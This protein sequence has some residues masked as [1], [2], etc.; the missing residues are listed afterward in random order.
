[1]KFS[2]KW[3]NDTINLKDITLQEVID[4]LTLAG[5][6]IDSIQNIKDTN[7]KIIDISITAN[8]Q[9]TSCIMGIAE[10]ISCIFN[11][12]QNN[13]SSY[14]NESKFTQNLCIDTIRKIK[15]TTSPRWIIHYLK[16]CEIKS[17]HIF[18]D[19]IQYIKI[20]WG[21]AIDIFDAEKVN[22]KAIEH[23]FS[24]LKNSTINSTS[25]NNQLKY[26]IATQDIIIYMK[27]DN[28]KHL[29]KIQADN[30]NTT[31]HVNQK[32][33]SE[34]HHNSIQAYNEALKLLN[35]YTKGIQGKTYRHLTT[36]YNENKIYLKKKKIYQT[37]GKT[38]N[39]FKNFLST[40]HILQILQQLYLRPTY[41]NITKEFIVHIPEYRSKDLL[42][43]IDII[44]EIGRIYGFNE[45]KSIK[46]NKIKQ[47]TIS[48]KTKNLKKAHK[49]LRD[50]GLSEVV[51]YSFNQQDT[52]IN[53]QRIEIYNPLIKDQSH[54][55]YSIALNLINTNIYNINQNIINNEFFEIGRI[56]YLNNQEYQENIQITGLIGNN[57]FN[58][59]SWTNK[60]TS[61]HWLQAKGLLEIL[62]ERMFAN[63]TWQPYY[64]Q[65]QNAF[66]SSIKEHINVEKSSYIL[67]QKT[68][69]IIGILAE[70]K[71]ENYK[72]E[73]LKYV[74]EINFDLLNKSIQDSTNMEYLFKSYSTYPS[75]TR[76]ISISLS[77]FSYINEIKD[78][79]LNKNYPF[80]ES[81]NIFNEYKTSSTQ[82]NRKIG[83][84]II[85]RSKNRTLKENDII[86]THQNIYDLLIE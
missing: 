37:L 59:N 80:V 26:D 84:R 16:G 86:A 63:I 5:F 15:N 2:W 1:M 24:K 52:N 50:I 33:N 72:I 70:L 82:Y 21:I 4:R 41:D 77:K 56:F 31:D 48:K 58:R 85:Y 13:K 57:Y 83:L 7:D 14:I 3:L 62:F 32:N 30:T 44:E 43:P 11:I 60:P 61:M 40:N 35:I 67:N 75:I 12:P 45:F 74:F 69:E 27:T 42:R 38:K 64:K 51:N 36:K 71:Q 81:V 73:H 34:L 78:K 46:P 28:Y 55:Q 53:H 20:K 76:D 9:D 18:D 47:G 23:L 25:I 8:R 68:K 10:E 6:E 66:I 22:S 19:I 29:D 79:I 65:K 49:I 39:R 17:N 54:L